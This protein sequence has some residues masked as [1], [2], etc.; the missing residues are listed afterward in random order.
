VKNGLKNMAAILGVDDEATLRSVVIKALQKTGYQAWGADDGR[1]ALRLA[2]QHAGSIGL[3]I[4]DR[5]MPGLSGEQTIAALRQAAPGLPVIVVSGS[6]DFLLGEPSEA[7]RRNWAYL[8][9]PFT[10]QQ[11]L[12]SVQQAIKPQ[13]EA[14]KGATREKDCVHAST[15]TQ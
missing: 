13:I 11:L 8:E 2:E 1:K 6:H 15:V 14:G 5:T 10:I 3:A 4:V 9:K 7:E 12:A